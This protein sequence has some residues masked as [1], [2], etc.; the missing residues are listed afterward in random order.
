MLMEARDEAGSGLSESALRDELVTLVLAG[1]ETTANALTFALVLLSQH[2]HVRRAVESEV[3][4]ALGGREPSLADLPRLPYTL[5]VIEEVL[6]LYPPA[7]IMEREALEDD[8][9]MGHRIAKGSLVIV[10]PYVTHRLP[11][12]WPNPEGFDP[13]RFSAKN[14]EGRDKH[15]YIP[16]GG[17]PR[18]CIGNA[19]ALME[20]QVILPML[21]QRF[22]LELEAGYR[23][24]LEPTVTLRPV[25]GVPM[26]IRPAEPARSV[27]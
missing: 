13:S 10:S 14:K 22:R 17:G 6:R 2:P 11:R 25:G 8:V 1:H 24:D 12:L 20:M 19:F 23:L 18:T 3:D 5:Q 4:Q 7:W 27:A 16:F 21:V 9:I 26:R 15:A